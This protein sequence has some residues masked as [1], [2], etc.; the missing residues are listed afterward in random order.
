MDQKN[1]SSKGTK[2]LLKICVY[3]ARL[4]QGQSSVWLICN[5]VQW[6]WSQGG[7]MALAATLQVAEALRAPFKMQV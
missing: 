2:A 3:L 4:F 1:K 6:R 5:T 7:T